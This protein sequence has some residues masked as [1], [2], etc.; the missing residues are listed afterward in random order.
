MND[1]APAMTTTTGVVPAVSSPRFANIAS[2]LVASVLVFFLATANA[3]DT[4]GCCSDHARVTGKLSPS[5]ACGVNTGCSSSLPA[6]AHLVCMKSSQS[7][8]SLRS[9]PRGAVPG[10]R[11]GTDGSVEKSVDDDHES[12]PPTPTQS[13]AADVARTAVLGGR[14]GAGSGGGDSTVCGVGV[15]GTARGSHLTRTTSA[16]VGF[17]DSFT[18][19][20]SSSAPSGSFTRATFPSRPGASMIK[21][22]EEVSTSTPQSAAQV[23]AGSGTVMAM[24]SPSSHAAEH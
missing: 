6:R 11:G 15:G 18:A 14:S 7:E 24:T 10:S 9:M 17:F 20:E 1:D 21:V 23:P 16:L 12:V 2:V 3:S 4:P 19:I 5:N 13:F 8:A 22:D